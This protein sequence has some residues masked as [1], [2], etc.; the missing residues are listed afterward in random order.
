MCDS[1]ILRITEQQAPLQFQGRLRAHG[2][3]VGHLNAEPVVVAQRMQCMQG[4]QR[5]SSATVH[6]TLQQP[7]PARGQATAGEGQTEQFALVLVQITFEQLDHRGEGR[8]QPRFAKGKGRS[9]QQGGTLLVEGAPGGG[10]RVVA[11]LPRQSA[12]PAEAPEVSA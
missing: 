4:V 11:V 12:P 1:F 2:D 6:Q 3:G 9:L 7:V 8:F 5:F 10:T